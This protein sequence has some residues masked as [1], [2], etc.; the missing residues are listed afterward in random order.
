MTGLIFPTQQA[1]EGCTLPLLLLVGHD[2]QIQLTK[3]VCL[4][5]SHGDS[6]FTPWTDGHSHKPIGVTIPTVM[7]LLY[8]YILHIKQVD[9][10]SDQGMFHS[11]IPRLS[12]LKRKREPGNIGG[13]TLCT[14][15][16]WNLAAPIGLQNRIMWMC[17]HLK[18]WRKSNK[19]F[20]NQLCMQVKTVSKHYRG[21]G[22]FVRR[23]LDSQ[24]T[25]FFISPS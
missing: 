1:G 20:N 16:N 25:S 14:S 15:G 23:I 22:E 13:I 18:A 17:G 24:F 2:G 21:K 7:Q 10:Y 8:M 4:T 6:R 5:N 9:N 3:W 12:L 19:A 11:L